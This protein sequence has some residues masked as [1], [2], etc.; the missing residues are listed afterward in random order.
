MV[1]GPSYGEAAGG[2]GQLAQALVGTDRPT[3]REP[4]TAFHEKVMDHSTKTFPSPGRLE[5]G[6][7][8]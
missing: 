6:A 5:T 8:K 2:Q 4:I 3:G 1:T 7:D